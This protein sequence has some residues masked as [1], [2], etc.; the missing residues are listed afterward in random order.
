MSEQIR[1]PFQQVVDELIRVLTDK[2]FTNKRAALCARLFAES[3][4]D[5][6]YSHGLNRF[7]RF[8]AMID[9]GSINIHAE[10]VQVNQMGSIEQWDGNRGPGNLNAYEMMQRAIDLASKNGLGMIALRN[11]NHWMRGGTYGWQAADAGYVGICWTNTNQNLP[12]WGATEA[13]I[14]NN[15]LII[16][17]PREKG[18]VILDMA[19]SQFSYGAL[20][21][22]QKKGHSLPVPGGYDTS[23]NLTSDPA[24]IEASYR[25]LPIGFWK[26]SALSIALDMMASALSAGK[27]TYQISS[28][29]LKETQLSQ[30]FLAI[31]MTTE[32]SLADSILDATVAHLHGSKTN[33]GEQ[34]YYPG[35]RTLA[36]RKE[37]I[38]Y[39]IPVD[40]DVWESI[41]GR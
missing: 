25:P 4:Q 26:G 28:D 32:K 10:P 30:C 15:P 16:A 20:S 33:P 12:P 35:E 27:A 22:Y 23:G 31:S 5:G 7:D 13:R 3:S 11:T 38:K 14:G 19:M 40:T 24:T 21:S 34:V 8:M 18:H 39:G 6:V 29:S 17:I 41:K 1:I 2:G 37:N 36:K 9:N